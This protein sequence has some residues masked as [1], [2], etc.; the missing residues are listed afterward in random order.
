M[1]L[2]LIIGESCIT[3]IIKK[4]LAKWPC[5]QKTCSRISS[6]SFGMIANVFPEFTK[7]SLSSWDIRVIF[8]N[9]DRTKGV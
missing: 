4:Y 7:K 6:W 3:P 2:K 9:A 1:F 8:L 5:D